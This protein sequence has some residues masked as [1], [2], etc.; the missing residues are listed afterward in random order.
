[1]KYK[2][3][4]RKTAYDIDYT[5][6]KQYQPCWTCEKLYTGCEWVTNRTPVPGWI[7]K[8]IYIKDNGKYCDSYKIESC[9]KYKRKDIKK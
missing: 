4:K 1:M 2:N 9:P 5:N 3:Y 8:P 6:F 7:A